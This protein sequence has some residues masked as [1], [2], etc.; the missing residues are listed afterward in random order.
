MNARFLGTTKAAGLLPCL[1]LMLGIPLG[2]SSASGWWNG[3]WHYRVPVEFTAGTVD[4]LRKPAEAQL[5]FTAL[6]GS[7]GTQGKFDPATI[8]IVEVNGSG[9]VIDEDVAFQFDPD[10]DYNDSTKAAGTLVILMSGTTTASAKRMYHIYFDFS[11][12]GGAPATV[13][14]QVRVE[15]GLWDEGQEC[16]AISSVTGRVFYQKI[17]AGFSSWQDKDSIDWVG[18]NPTNDRAAGSSRGVPNACYPR[19]YFHPGSTG[20]AASTTTL[21]HQGPLKATIRAINQDGDWECQWDFYPEYA[22]FT[23]LQVDSTYWVLYEG[24]PGGEL[25]PTV[26]FITRSNG[27]QTMASDSLTTDIPD[28]EWLYFS[29][30]N[31][32]RSLFVGHEEDDTQIDQYYPMTTTTPVF[33][34]MT[35]FGFGREAAR[36]HLTLVPQ[37]F[38]FGIMEGTGFTNSAT[39]V[40]SAMGTVSSSLGQPEKLESAPVRLLSPHDGATHQSR[41]PKL[42]WQAYPSAT[43]YRVQVAHDSTFDAGTIA[44]DATASDTTYTVPSQ[45]GTLIGYYWHVAAVMSSYTLPYGS[46]WHFQTLGGLPNKVT[47]VYPANGDWEQHDSAHCRWNSQPAVVKYAIEWTTDSLFAWPDMDSTLTDT[48]T[49]L[50]LEVGTYYWRVRARSEAGWGPPSDIRYFNTRLTDV[51]DTREIPAD[52]KL[53]QNF[54][55]PFNPSTV[56]EYALPAS[57]HVN[58]AVFNTL[59]Q[60][61][62]TLVEET[63]SAGLHRVGFDAR[64][65]VTSGVYFYRI[66]VNGQTLTRTMLLLR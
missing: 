30:P 66:T 58:L 54:P 25:E 34:R 50:S 51:S 53:Y 43:G 65:H 23:M 41:T 49:V 3:S 16:W 6:T 14:P 21:V 12:Q 11:G 22:R 40:R 28:E 62:A 4:C 35:V 64:A 31:V 39:V 2:E 20:S 46:P 17:G 37:H 42:V 29:D 48:S 44:V 8:R 52:L 26:D 56:I 32:N 61:V 9:D 1:L 63:Q 19:G 60:S 38:V 13:T 18:Y 45:L 36:S 7:L 27:V 10:S 47:L 59:G 24:T 57:G 5:N 55:N 33:G 15:D